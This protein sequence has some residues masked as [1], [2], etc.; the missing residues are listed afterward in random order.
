M[1]RSSRSS[2]RTRWI[3]GDDAGSAALEFIVAGLVLLVPLV[4]LVVALGMIQGHALGAETAARHAAR[5]V[6][7]ASG[8]AAA[9][10][11]MR[12]VVTQVAG[13]YGVDPDQ[14]TAELSCLGTAPEC[15]MA[16]AT[17]AVTV[18][19]VVPLPLVPP[20]LGLDRIAAVPVEAAAAQ[21]MSRVWGGG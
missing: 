11:R 13:E 4:Y 15:P 1:R 3:C 2:D 20:V 9:D 7:T 14:V 12:A 17:V 16:G 18:Q 6:S 21:K 5:A 8:P 19:V 10:A